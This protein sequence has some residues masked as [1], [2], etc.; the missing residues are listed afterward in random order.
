MGG[1]MLSTP[2][3]HCSDTVGAAG[4]RLPRHLVLSIGFALLHDSRR[5]ATITTTEPSR[6]AV[7]R[8]T[9]FL[10]AIRRSAASRRTALALAQS[11]RVTSG[12]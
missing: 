10:D 11:Y 4:D 2:P 3:R 7:I 8:R 9:E 1:Q 12:E 5:T 6:V